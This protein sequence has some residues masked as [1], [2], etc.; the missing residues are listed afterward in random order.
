MSDCDHK[1]LSAVIDGEIKTVC[2]IC[3]DI[4]FQTVGGKTDVTE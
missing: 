3:D 4:D 2:P 1:K